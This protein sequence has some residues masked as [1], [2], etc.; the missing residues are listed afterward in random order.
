VIHLGSIWIRGAFRNELV[1]SM[2]LAM[3]CKCVAVNNV[4]SPLLTFVVEILLA[5]AYWA[6]SS[7]VVVCSVFIVDGGIYGG[8]SV[9]VG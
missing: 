6:Q 8:L 3:W 2:L 1:I 4:T 9:E 7:A 5:V